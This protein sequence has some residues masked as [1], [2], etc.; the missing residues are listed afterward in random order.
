M[1]QTASAPTPEQIQ[2]WRQA[3]APIAAAAV[4]EVLGTIQ[5]TDA[6]ERS[7]TAA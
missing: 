6:Q 1:E 3:Y 2:R 4:A 7:E 5:A